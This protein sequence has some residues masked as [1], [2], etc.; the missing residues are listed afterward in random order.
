M[1]GWG[2]DL[3]SIQSSTQPS[4]QPSLVTQQKGLRLSTQAFG[5]VGA[6]AYEA[7]SAVTSARTFSARAVER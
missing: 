3:S 5:R 6:S 4:I 1:T 2:T 7:V